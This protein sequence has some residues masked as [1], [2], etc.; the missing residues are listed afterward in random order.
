MYVGPEGR[1]RNDVRV[2]CRV[3][4]IPSQR[5]AWTK[6]AERG[7]AA[8]V[9]IRVGRCRSAR[10]K[11][12]H[13]RLHMQ[14][15]SHTQEACLEPDEE[16]KPPSFGLSALGH[17]GCWCIATLLGVSRGHKIGQGARVGFAV[18]RVLPGTYRRTRGPFVTG[19]IRNAAGALLVIRF[20]F[21]SL[22]LVSL[23]LFLRLPLNLL[24]HLTVVLALLGCF[25]LFKGLPRSTYGRG[26]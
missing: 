5:C 4:H 3:A 16:S 26:T 6:E 8:R 13:S 17:L 15:R 19:R 7:G 24:V 9:Q 25:L 12:D 20:G 1:G 10:P 21:A 2:T 14:L 23:V 22:M 11:T 18:V